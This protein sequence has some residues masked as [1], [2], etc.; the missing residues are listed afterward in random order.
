MTLDADEYYLKEELHNAKQIILKNNYDATACFMRIFFKEPIYEYFPY[1][2]IN[3]VSL[4]YKLDTTKPFKLAHPYPA[5]ID[6]TRRI[7]NVTSFYHFQ[8]N[9]VEMYHM[10][11][12]R[13]DIAKKI[14]NVSNRGNYGDTTAFFEKLKIWTPEMGVLHPHPYIGKFFTE[15]RQVENIFDIDLNRQ[16]AVCCKSQ[17]LQRCARCKKIRYCS[18]TCQIEHWSQHKPLCIPTN[19]P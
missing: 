15:F 2:K 19:I 1:D 16:C 18:K 14:L 6:P 9:E 12:V 13:K 11:F 8:R 5:V 7:E 3:S 10:T 4:I 17:N